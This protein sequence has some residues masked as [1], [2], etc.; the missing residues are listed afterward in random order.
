[1]LY[2]FVS[3]L[4][5]SSYSATA[6]F[7]A[8]RVMYSATC[9]TRCYYGDQFPRF[10]RIDLD[11]HFRRP[12]PVERMGPPP[13]STR[14]NFYAGIFV[15]KALSR[16]DFN[17]LATFDDPTA[18]GLGSYLW[19]SATTLTSLAIHHGQLPRAQEAS[20]FA[21]GTIG[22]GREMGHLHRDSALLFYCRP[23]LP[24]PPL[25]ASTSNACWLTTLVLILI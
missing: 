11:V 10:A 2:C 12:A 13:G 6:A 22:P 14:S 9:C 3:L 5:L 24:W 19:H 7:A 8:D 1:L 21:A 25:R 4:H 15:G 17:A 16:L 20:T 23:V 18:P